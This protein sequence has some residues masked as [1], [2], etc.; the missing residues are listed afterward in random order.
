VIDLVAKDGDLVS[1]QFTKRAIQSKEWVYSKECNLILNT[2]TGQIEC[3][4]KKLK[5]NAQK[6]LDKCIEDR[7]T[8]DITKIIQKL[9][10][11]EA[12]LFPIRD[13]GGVYFV[14]TKFADF[15]GKIE[16]FVLGLGGRIN[17][18]PVPAGTAS[19]DRSVADSIV[20]GI[21]S[22][23]DDLNKATDDFTINTRSDTLANQAK[24]IRDCK[25]KVEAYATLLQDRVEEL[26]DHIEL[27]NQKLLKKLRGLEQ[28]KLTAPPTVNGIQ[29]IHGHA[30]T[31]IL[32]WMGSKGWKSD[33]AK[34]V[35]ESF[36]ISVSDSTIGCQLGGWKVRGE[37]P[38][39]SK[40]QVKDLEQRAEEAMEVA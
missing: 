1:F 4:D 12:D 11:A 3:E 37:V 30:V 10:D 18:F 5:A 26:Q 16:N 21:D 17:R 22:A 39:L 32:R 2:S 34:A 7:T 29:R 14:P 15:V 36:D 19:G 8:A 33:K 24:Y 25:I 13:Q 28:E 23:L 20:N 31:A 35:L 38:N 6:L 9:F 40:E 27:C